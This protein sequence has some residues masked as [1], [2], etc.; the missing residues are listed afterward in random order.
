MTVSN[1]PLYIEENHGTLKRFEREYGT[2]IRYVEE[3][4]ANHYVCPVEGVRELL[5]KSDPALA[6]SELIFPSRETLDRPTDLRPLKP[7]EER[8]VEAAFQAVLGA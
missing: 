1:W 5:E 6:G 2:K 4:T 7:D 3:I 8:D